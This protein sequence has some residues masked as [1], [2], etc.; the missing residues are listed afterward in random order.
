MRNIWNDEALDILRM[1]G[2][3]KIQNLGY[4]VWEL[5]QYCT[6]TQALFPALYPALPFPHHHIN[7]LIK[8]M[9]FQFWHLS[10]VKA[11]LRSIFVVLRINSSLMSSIPLP[12]CLFTHSHI[13]GHFVICN[14]FNYSQFKNI[15]DTFPCELVC[16]GD[17]F[18]GYK[19]TEFHLLHI[20]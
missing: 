11:Y 13:Q 3:G 12:W 19:A 10:F 15:T 5:R 2:G 6:T 8:S 17:I 7:G 14:N 4:L 16:C 18:N 9:T 1:H 20:R